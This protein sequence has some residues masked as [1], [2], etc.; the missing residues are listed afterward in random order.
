MN[1]VRYCIKDTLAFE[2]ACEPL[3]GYSC[4]L[5]TTANLGDHLTDEETVLDLRG[6]ARRV[7]HSQLY[8]SLLYPMLS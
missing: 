8:A 5:N 1:L 2:Q 6:T 7:P 3:T 4:T